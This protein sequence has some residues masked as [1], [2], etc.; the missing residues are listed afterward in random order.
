MPRG[1]GSDY[2]GAMRRIALVLAL[3]FVVSDAQAKKKPI[4]TGDPLP[5]KPVVD[6]QCHDKGAVRV[7]GSEPST[8]FA[9]VRK[10][11]VR[12]AGEACCA[13]WA[14][15]DARF[16]TVDAY[17]QIVGEA[18]IKG[19]EGYDVSQCYELSFT[20]K[21]GKPGVGLYLDGGYK[22]PKS[23]AWTPSA[24]EST[25][26]AKLVASL[27]SAMVPKAAYECG[28]V[29]ALPLAERALHFSSKEPGKAPVRWAVVGGALLVVARLQDDGRWV[30][31]TV[32]ATESD[33]C[34][35]RAYRP[36]AVFDVTGD[37]R[38]EIFVH[39]DFG[40][41]FGDVALGLDP[42]GTEGRWIEVATAVYGSTA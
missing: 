34:R 14:R 21:K 36:R 26:L 31:R 35:P 41:A 4:H 30:A 6:E 28:S 33:T 8:P 11:V 20:T 17:G 19:G 13:Q 27:E 24:A 5:A 25:A 22:P 40:D 15:K 16:A 39:E 23:A 9:V 18:E 1:A 32:L 38:P 42:S 10:G 29:K 7:I 3:L 12:S 2:H 37:G